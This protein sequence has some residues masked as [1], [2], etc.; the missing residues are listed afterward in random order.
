MNRRSVEL[1]S[2]LALQAARIKILESDLAL[3][4]SANKSL[5]VENR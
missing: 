2:G 4:E 3:K 1:S 5:E